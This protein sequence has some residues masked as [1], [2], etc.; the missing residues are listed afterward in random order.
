MAKRDI[1]DYRAEVQET[2][3]EHRGISRRDLIKRVGVGALSVPIFSSVL[4]ACTSEEDPAEVADAAGQEA[5]GLT[6]LG[7]NGGLVVTWYAQGKRTM[8]KWA[9]LFGVQLDWVDGELNAQTQRQRLET[10]V[11]AKDYDIAAITAHEAGTVVPPVQELIGKGTRVMQMISR[12]AGPDEELDLLTW[13]EQSS[14]EMGLQVSRALFES[15]GGQGTV[16][17]TQGP[18][19]FTGAQERHRGFEAALAEYPGMEL[20][21]TDFGNW[22]VNRSRTLW[23]S[24]LNRFSQ[25]DCGY[26]H[27]DDMAFAALE[28]MNAAG[29]GGQIG[30]GGADA[31]PEAIRAV[32]DGRFV[33]TVRHS[34]CRMHMYPVVVGVAH[35]LG[36][37]ENV[38]EKVVIDGPLVTGE[39]AATLLFV[40]EDGILIA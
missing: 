8:E 22:D 36:A 34:A 11:A 9:N 32:G 38:P 24:Y 17:E 25:I 26:F 16:I 15:V 2:L 6:M 28:A 14:F 1:A 39:N 35:A 3:D 10:A 33:A 19:A 37:I 23:E 4:A 30:I 29:R 31:M 27:N 5:A 12:I 21:E 40:Q 7:S 13:F 18:A 20:L